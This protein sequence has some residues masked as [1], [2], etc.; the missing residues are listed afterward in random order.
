MNYNF[1][2]YA[3]IPNIDSISNYWINGVNPFRN[4]RII[5]TGNGEPDWYVSSIK[6]SNNPIG[7]INLSNLIHQQGPPFFFFEEALVRSI[8]EAIERYSASNYFLA[9][10]PDLR[11]VDVTKKF[12]RC[13]D[14]EDAPISFKENGITEKIEH[15]PVIKLIDNS[16]DYL[17]Y[18][19]VHLGYLKPIERPLFCPPISTGC[20]FFNDKITVILKGILEVIE[21][22]AIMRWWYQNFPNI[23][24]IEEEDIV[25]FDIRE[26]LRRIKE[27]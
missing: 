12:V 26:R 16:T 22:D 23:K 20:S 24:R 4:S 10:Q 18:E 9:E 3:N 2:K 7:Y 21:R 8:G 13:G 1:L 6:L 25:S 11:K 27:N 15:T 14:S 5:K 19:S 17:P